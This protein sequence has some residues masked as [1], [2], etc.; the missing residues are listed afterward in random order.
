MKLPLSWLAEYVELDEL[1]LETLAKAMT[2]VGLEVEE[3]RRVGLPMPPGEKHE[4]K[5]TGLSWPAD[6]FVVAQVDEVM[7]HPNAD[8][9]VLCR[10]SDGSEEFIVLT[11]APNL[12]EYK[13][14]GPLAQPKGRLCPGGRDT[15]MGIAWTKADDSKKNENPRR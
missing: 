15:L 9:L 11:G 10:V 1:D 8:R 12:F 13:G 14:A 7:P 4:F 6:K 5:Y 2:M 3:I